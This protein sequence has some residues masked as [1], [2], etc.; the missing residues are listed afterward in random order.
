MNSCFAFSIPKNIFAIHQNNTTHTPYH[1][2]RIYKLSKLPAIHPT[3]NISPQTDPEPLTAPYDI[4][5]HP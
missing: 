5:F 2:M 3:K 4:P 1:N